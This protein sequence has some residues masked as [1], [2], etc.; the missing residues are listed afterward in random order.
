VVD[1]VEAGLARPADP[2]EPVEMTEP[3]LP[4][5]PVAV[6]MGVGASGAPPT[7]SSC[8][9]SDM[10]MRLYSAQ[11]RKRGTRGVA[12]RWAA[13]HSPGGSG[14]QEWGAATAWPSQGQSFVP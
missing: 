2:L 5:P 11:G 4:A 13:L 7:P 14:V 1:A 10:P 9:Q 3:G 8:A 6:A 12:E